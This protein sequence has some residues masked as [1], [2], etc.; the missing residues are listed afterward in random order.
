[1][2]SLRLLTF[3]LWNYYVLNLLRLETIT[4]SDATLSDIN[5]VFCYVL[6]H[7][8]LKLLR[9]ETITFSDAKLSYINLL[10][11]Y[12]LSHYVLKLLLLE[13][14]TFSN[15]TLSEINVVLFCHRNGVTLWIL[16][17]IYYYA[18][19]YGMELTVGCPAIMTIFWVCTFMFLF[20]LFCC[21]CFIIKSLVSA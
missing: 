4:F 12:F 1:M 6:S 20:Q 10:L 9:L 19:R 2:T 3:T 13:T 18:I 17:S 15:A 7:Y 5:V 11:C 21:L 14:I 8:V 16:L